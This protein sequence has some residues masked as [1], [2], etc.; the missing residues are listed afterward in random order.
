MK[1]RCSNPNHPSYDRYGGRGIVVCERWMRF[2]NFFADMGPRPS[3]GYEI[4]REDNNKGYEP[5]NCAW[6]TKRKNSQNTS[7]SKR[8]ILNGVEYSCMKDAADDLGVSEGTISAWCQGTTV[9]GR[10]YGPRPNCSSVPVYERPLMGG[11]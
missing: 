7:Q 4:D 5:G 2:E 3:K 9:A 1:S 11:S 6:V 8:W 10:R